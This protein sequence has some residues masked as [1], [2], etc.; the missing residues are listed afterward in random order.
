[1][2]LRSISEATTACGG[3]RWL[4]RCPVA[5]GNEEGGKAWTESKGIMHMVALTEEWRRLWHIG[6]NPVRTAGLHRWCGPEAR[7]GSAGVVRDRDEGE[8]ARGKP[9]QR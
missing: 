4:M 6:A 3:R 1:V 8:K 9:E 2:V 7:E 5:L